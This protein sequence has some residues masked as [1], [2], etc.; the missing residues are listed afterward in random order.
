MIKIV[1]ADKMQNLQRLQPSIL[2]ISEVQSKRPY[3]N[4]RLRLMSTRV[5]LNGEKVSE[6]FIDRIVND[7]KAN[8]ALPLVADVQKIERGDFRVGLGH[9]F[10]QETQSFLSTQIGGF[11]DFEK[12]NDEYGISLIGEARVYK[13]NAKITDAI[14]SLYNENSLAFSFEIIAGSISIEDGVTTVGDSDKNELIAMCLVSRP[15]FVEA[16]ALSLVAEQKSKEEE[17]KIK[18]SIASAHVDLSGIQMAEAS[19][20]TVTRWI[21]EAV[22]KYIGEELGNGI[23]PHFLNVGVSSALL[24][25]ERTGLLYRAEYVVRESD[26]FVSDLYQVE[27]VR[28]A[29]AA[30]TTQERE[31]QKLEL[32]DVLQEALKEAIE[33]E[34]IETGEVIAESAETASESEESAETV[35]AQAAGTA[36]IVED[37]ADQHIT[38]DNVSPEQPISAEVDADAVEKLKARIAELELIE[39]KWLASEE[40]ARAAVIAAKK[41]KLTNYAKASGLDLSAENVASAVE[42]MDY[43]KLVSLVLEAQVTEPEDDKETAQVTASHDVVNP[44][45]SDMK[46]VGNWLF[47]KN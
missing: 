10:D 8:L 45:T 34:Q 43:E 40:A 41:E 32:N 12:V 23:W 26:V 31:E 13:R 2:S 46:L 4:I 25:E 7:K 16:V 22:Y 21:I 15:A 28:V 11:V 29:E 19:L 33:G 24:Y 44:L 27:T 3:V 30:S 39:Q 1:D 17:E 14:I 20:E 37:L 5:N 6:A 42:A 38:I 47:Q 36:D 35:Q 9:M 18:A